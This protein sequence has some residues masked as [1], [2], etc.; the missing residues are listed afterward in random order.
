[1]PKRMNHLQVPICEVKYESRIEGFCNK[2][3]RSYIGSSLDGVGDYVMRG[4]L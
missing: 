4:K 2:I 3:G 1:M